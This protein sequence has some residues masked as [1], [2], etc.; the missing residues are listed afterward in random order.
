MPKRKNRKGKLISASEKPRKK[1]DD[2]V[3]KKRRLGPFSFKA[4]DGKQYRLTS[5]QK[6]WC[7][8]YLEKGANFTIASLEAYKVTNKHLCKIPWKLLSDKEKRRRIATENTASHIGAENLRKLPIKN[9]IDKILSDEG[10]TDE[11]VRLEHFKNIKQD[12]NLPAKNQ[13]IDMYYK[14][15]GA[16]APEKSESQVTV[17]EVVKYAGSKNKQS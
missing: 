14:K 4:T 7:D 17:V 10:Y 3:V 11:V 16:Y 13:A 2:Q 15:K 1:K 6:H 8:I 5:K 9:Y 12:K